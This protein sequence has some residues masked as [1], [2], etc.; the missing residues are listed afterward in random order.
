MEHKAEKTPMVH[1]D[2]DIAEFELERGFSFQWPDDLL[3]I[4]DDYS[5]KAT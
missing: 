3:F 4:G 5:T 1:P 2:R